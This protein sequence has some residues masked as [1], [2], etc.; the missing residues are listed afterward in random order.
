[1]NGKN[2]ISNLLLDDWYYFNCHRVD[3]DDYA[4]FSAPL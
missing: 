1:M 4:L 3:I 2:T